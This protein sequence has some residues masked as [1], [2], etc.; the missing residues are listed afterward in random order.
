MSPDFKT[1]EFV[2]RRPDGACGY[3]TE[4]EHD[5]RFASEPPGGYVPSILFV[6]SPDRVWRSDNIDPRYFFKAR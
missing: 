5:F 4:E 1:I 2:A 3:V 6:S